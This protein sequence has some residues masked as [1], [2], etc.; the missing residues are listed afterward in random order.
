MIYYILSGMDFVKIGV[1]EQKPAK[2][3]KEM[4][5]G[6]PEMLTLLV[7]HDG[8]RDLERKIHN[9]LFRHQKRGEWFKFNQTVKL[10]MFGRA[11]K[12]G[13]HRFY[14]EAGIKK[15]TPI[16]GDVKTMRKRGMAWAEIAGAMNM[17]PR[18]LRES[19]GF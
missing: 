7:T 2:R 19:C 5:T 11:K 6:N 12:F 16:T 17:T 3:L 8:G 18:K 14:N 1:T 13:N 10:Y 15:C 4:Q 9:Y